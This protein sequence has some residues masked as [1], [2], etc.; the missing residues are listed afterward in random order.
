MSRS[1][2]N[3][4]DRRDT[5]DKQRAKRL[6]DLQLQDDFLIAERDPLYGITHGPSLKK[7]EIKKPQKQYVKI[8]VPTTDAMAN[9]RN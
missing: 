8:E 1:L 7:R 4:I 3:S 2:R 6:L 5:Q 9:A